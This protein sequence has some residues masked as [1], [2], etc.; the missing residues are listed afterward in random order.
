MPKLIRVLH[1]TEYAYSR[2]VQLNRHRLMLRPRDG[3]DLWV[4][5]A[6]LRITPRARLRWFF[7]AF[8]NSVANATFEQPTDRLAIESELILRRYPLD[9]LKHPVS[10][11]LSPF[12][13]SYS[14]E[15]ATDLYPYLGV[16]VREDECVIRDWLARVL[17]DPPDTAFQFLRGLGDAIHRSIAYSRREEMG[18]Q[19]A[20]ETIRRARGTCRDFAFLFMEAA[21]LSGFATRF[22]TG[23]LNDSATSVTGGGSTHAWADAFI[24]DEGWIEFDPT[25]R[26]IGGRSLIRVGTTRTPDQAS[27]ISGSFNG[28]RSAFAGLTVSVEV[29]ETEV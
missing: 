3:H 17:P 1:R 24:P 29:T 6:F 12:P 8:G 11:H 2:P 22:V 16:Q 15:E 25:N 10:P 26:I 5:D 27:P 19:S 20:G 13:C 28:P 4:D 23:Y 9:H 18:T 21:R 14:A 7:D